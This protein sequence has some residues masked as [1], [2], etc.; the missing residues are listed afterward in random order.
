MANQEPTTAASLSFDSCGCSAH[1]DDHR[2]DCPTRAHVER[3]T[4]MRDGKTYCS[5]GRPWPCSFG[6]PDGA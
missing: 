5:C 2:A 4:K 3:P 6:G 1:H